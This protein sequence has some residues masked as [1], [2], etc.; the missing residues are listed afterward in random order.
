M[1]TIFEV[2]VFILS[3]SCG[4]MGLLLLAQKGVRMMKGGLLYRTAV[5]I[6]LMGILLA[7]ITLSASFEGLPAELPD[8]FQVAVLVILYFIAY[9]AWVQA[10]S[11]GEG[12]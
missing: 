3:V 7:G 1:P 2:A 10:K 12:V 8:V 5:G 11:I 6:A 4:I 9:S